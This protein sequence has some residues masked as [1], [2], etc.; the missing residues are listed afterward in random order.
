MDHLWSPW[1]M[2]YLR[3]EDSLPPTG[4]RG[5][6]FCDL[7]AQDNDRDNLIVRRG[8]HAYVIL[9]RYPYN[10]GHL[11][12][13]PYAHVPNFEALDDDTLA[14][15]M[16]LSNQAQAALR[17]MYD[18][19]AFNL[20]ANIGRPAGAGIADHVHMHIV[21]RWS[22]DTNFMTAVSGTRVIPEDLRETFDLAQA[23]WP[24]S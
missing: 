11:M 5:C 6:I 9:N 2:P 20:G 4:P 16:R 22:G 8:E 7:P 13:V 14:E 3:N 21:P 18:P 1:R 19:H 24:A 15:I 17:A 12:V 10:N 23:N